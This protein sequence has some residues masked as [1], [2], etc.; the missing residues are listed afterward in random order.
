MIS[1]PTQEVKMAI[2]YLEWVAGEGFE[3]GKSR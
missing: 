3:E 2:R 1:H